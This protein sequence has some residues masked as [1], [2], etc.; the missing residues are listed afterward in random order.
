M[1]RRWDGTDAEKYRKQAMDAAETARDA[2]ERAAEAASKAARTAKEWA[3]PRVKHAKEWAAPRVE[4]TWSDAKDWATPRAEHVVQAAAKK[5]KP[6]V[7]KAT[8]KT[9]HWVEVA[10]GAIVGAAI[11]A[12]LSAFDRAADEDSHESQR[13]GGSTW[14]KVLIPVLIAGAAGAA[15]VIWAK[16]DPGKDEWAGDDDDW[17]FEG[18]DD[19]SSR[20]RR[21]VNKAADATAAAAKRAAEAVTSAASMVAEQAGP[22]YTKAKDATVAEAKKLAEQA[23]PFVDKAKEQATPYVDK[24]VVAASTAATRAKE[25]AAPV[26]ERAK[27]TATNEAERI[28]ANVEAARHRAATGLADALDDAEDVWEDEGGTLE[29]GPAPAAAKKPRAPR[30]PV[31]KKSTEE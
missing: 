9:E 1:Q 24:A 7:K 20:L 5:A 21:D 4:S 12:V 28:K 23:G 16:R 14:A 13:K 8:N 29:D 25:A 26:V 6:Y 15:L 2:A 22:T 19:F 11:P 30:K 18:E 3:E 17:E 27:A 10:Q 31:A